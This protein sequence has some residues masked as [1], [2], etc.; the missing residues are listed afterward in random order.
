[1]LRVGRHESGRGAWLCAA[2]VVDCVEL[3]RKKK[4]FAR[5]FRAPVSS[6]ASDD[7]VAFFGLVGRDMADLTAA[8]GSAVAGNQRKG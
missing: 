5:A 6:T 4:A 2:T 7:I 1:M 8:D 3:A